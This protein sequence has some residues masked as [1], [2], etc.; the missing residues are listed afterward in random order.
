MSVELTATIKAVDEA[1]SKIKQVGD[2]TKKAMEKVEAS[3]EKADFSMKNFA[4]SISGVMTAGFSLYNAYD[5]IDDAQLAVKKSQD[6]LTSAQISAKSAQDSYNTAVEKYGVDSE[7]ARDALEKL[8]LAQSRVATSQEMLEEKQSRVN[9]AMVQMAIQVVPT[10]ITGLTS[11]KGMIGSL[12]G[13]FGTLRLSASAAWTAMAGPLAVL[14]ISIPI[15]AGAYQETADLKKE[16]DALGLTIEDVNRMTYEYAAAGMNL[17]EANIRAKA[18]IHAMFETLQQQA[19]IMDGVAA[20]IE[21]DANRIVDSF[22]RMNDVIV[23][24]SIW[25]EMWKDIER[26]TKKGIE[27]NVSLMDR[28]LGRTERGFV[29][30]PIIH[31][32]NI[33]INTGPISSN[34][35]IEKIAKAFDRRLRANIKAQH[36][37]VRG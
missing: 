9:E 34:M 24:H 12:S 15:M 22:E 8:E 37:L 30:S 20:S 4:V 26:V 17:I 10:M 32:T 13:A 25:P 36:Y 7:Q 28:G 23:G 27:A 1:S 19:T 31:K 29:T 21:E 14:G 2:N 16:L 3:A 33:V 18:E 5:R 35:D 6:A 11:L